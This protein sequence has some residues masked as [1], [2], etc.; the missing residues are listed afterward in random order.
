MTPRSFLR[1]INSS[2]RTD[3]ECYHLKNKYDTEHFKKS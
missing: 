2:A 1:V 3:D